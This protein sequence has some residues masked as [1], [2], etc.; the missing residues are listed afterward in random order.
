MFFPHCLER[1]A[2]GSNYL[3]HNV[4]YHDAFQTLLKYLPDTTQIS[5]EKCGLEHDC[6]VDLLKCVEIYF[7][8]SLAMK[9]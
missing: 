5:M 6:D 1:Y 3:K 9:F 4:S 8:E 2:N 7:L